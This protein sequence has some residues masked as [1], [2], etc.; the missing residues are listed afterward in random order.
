SCN[1]SSKIIDPIQSRCV[2]FKFKPLP[3][4][5][6]FSIID[7]ISKE[8][9]IKVTAE[10]KQ[11][12]YEVTKGDCRKV[13]NLLQSSAAVSQ[14][15]TDKTIYSI[16]SQALPEEVNDILNLTFKGDI[17]DARKKLLTVMFENGLSG[18]DIIKQIQSSIWKQD[19]ADLKKLEMVILCG[20]IEFRM[21]EGSD[22]FIQL[23]ALIAGMAHIN[24]K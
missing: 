12:L 4:E 13:E 16:A 15:V 11:A 18:L 17:L 22:E 7:K 9:N 19:I 23:E 1:F 6:I 8:E 5:D 20:E 10:A 3:K 2:V 14:E 21:V 24:K